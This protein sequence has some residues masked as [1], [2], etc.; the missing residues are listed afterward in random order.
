MP[1]VENLAMSFFLCEK[2]NRTEQI[3]DYEEY[4]DAGDNYDTFVSYCAY[5]HYAL[6]T[7]QHL[8]YRSNMCGCTCISLR[9]PSPQYMIW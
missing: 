1:K 3:L 4:S 7:D 2:E 5:T 9:E 8:P 6:C